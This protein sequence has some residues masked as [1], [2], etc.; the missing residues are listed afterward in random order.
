M[1]GAVRQEGGERVLFE[2][3]GRDARADMILQIIVQALELGAAE[4]EAAEL[5]RRIG[6]RRESGM[7]AIE[8]AFLP[9]GALAAARGRAAAPL[10][11]AGGGSC[12]LQTRGG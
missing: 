4:N 11:A 7:I 5:S 1:D 10:R 3:L 2:K 9:R 8:P 6:E 12:F